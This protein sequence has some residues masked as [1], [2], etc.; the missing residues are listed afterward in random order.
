MRDEVFLHNDSDETLELEPGEK[1][2]AILL[3]D[4]QTTGD[5]VVHFD[6]RDEG[7]Q[8]PPDCP[9]DAYSEE[10]AVEI[11]KQL[12][13][14][15]VDADEIIAEIEDNDDVDIDEVVEFVRTQPNS[16][17]K[18]KDVLEEFTKAELEAATT[19][20]PLEYS[21]TESLIYHEW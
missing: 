5:A 7:R 18:V 1:I 2:P 13:D 14:T 4:P 21:A 12:E 6:R 15:D 8:H 9:H 17:A 3:F 20:G 16:I 19:H 11:E 10:E